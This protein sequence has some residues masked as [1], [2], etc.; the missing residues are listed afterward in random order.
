MTELL[1]LNIEYLFSIYFTHKDKVSIQKYSFDSRFLQHWSLHEYDNSHILHVLE[2]FHILLES[3][4]ILGNLHRE[5]LDL[6]ILVL[7]FE[8]CH[9]I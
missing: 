9:L 4:D 2:N 7:D 8:I 6:E 5:L 3:G 1:A